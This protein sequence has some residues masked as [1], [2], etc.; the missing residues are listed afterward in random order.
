MD[1]RVLQDILEQLAALR[2]DQDEFKREI[3]A[4][5]QHPR[6]P[7]PSTPIAAYPEL[8]LTTP[9]V[10]FS[11]P[12]RNQLPPDHQRDLDERLL[13]TVRVDAPTFAGQLEPSVYLDWR[14]AMDNY[15][16]WYEMT[17]DRKVRFAKMKLIG[18]AH[19]YWHNVEHRR[20]TQRLP[21][22]TTWEDMKEKLR[23][24]CHSLTNNALWIGGRN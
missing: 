4:L 8:G 14:A 21:R 20:E 22:I 10:A 24:I 11:H 3:R 15:F 23:S 1:P 7:E 18:Q 16:E 13:R 2:A 12:P 6:T 19:W 9:P 17:D 5:V